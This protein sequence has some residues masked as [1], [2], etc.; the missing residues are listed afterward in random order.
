MNGLL[1]GNNKRDKRKML[2]KVIYHDVHTMKQLLIFFSFFSQV[3]KME[4]KPITFIAKMIRLV[5]SQYWFMYFNISFIIKSYS[6]YKWTDKNKKWEF[7]I[8]MLVC[9]VKQVDG[10]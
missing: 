8:N 3:K 2:K 7:N 1:K 9:N 6:Y 4:E 5:S 10:K